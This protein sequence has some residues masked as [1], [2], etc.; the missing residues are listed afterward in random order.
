[1]CGN[2]QVRFLEGEGAVRLPTYSTS[3]NIINRFKTNKK[4][5][6]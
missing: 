1:M 2:T 3:M 5:G 6:A 4:W